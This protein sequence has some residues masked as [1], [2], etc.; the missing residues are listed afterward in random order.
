MLGV[1]VSG[2]GVL[3]LTDLEPLRK[4]VLDLALSRATRNPKPET[5]NPKP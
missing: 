4:H 2:G 3:T 1:R 5:L